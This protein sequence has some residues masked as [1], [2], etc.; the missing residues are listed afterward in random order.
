M[1]DAKP[2]TFIRNARM[3]SWAM[4]PFSPERTTLSAADWPA[5]DGGGTM[6]HFITA[7]GHCYVPISMQ[8]QRVTC[9]VPMNYSVLPEGAA[10][11]ERM[12]GIWF[13]GLV[14]AY[15]TSVCLL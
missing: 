12:R 6:W 9:D 11:A 3:R 4:P 2:E 14:E 10:A 13:V 5:L 15:K 1:T 7:P 8:A